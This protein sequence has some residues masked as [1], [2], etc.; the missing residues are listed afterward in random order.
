[1]STVSGTISAGSPLL[2]LSSISDFLLGDDARA[3]NAG[4]NYAAGAVAEPHGDALSVA[5]RAVR[6]R[7]RV[8]IL[9]LLRLDR[10]W[11]GRTFER[12]RIGRRHHQC[13]VADDVNETFVQLI[14]PKNHLP[15]AVWKNCGASDTYI[16]DAEPTWVPAITAGSGYT[17]GGYAFTATGGGCA[18]EPQGWVKISGGAIAFV[19]VDPSALGSGCTSAPT[20]TVSGLGAGAGS[21]GAVTLNFYDEMNDAATCRP[22]PTMSP[23]R[24]WRARNPTGS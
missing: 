21:G 1:M 12:I 5:L 6:L 13:R 11:R 22:R 23:P 10:R 19:R 7:D 3:L 15:A 14:P 9:H 16:G 17:N 8:D 4:A 18:V 2:T 24:I 20:I